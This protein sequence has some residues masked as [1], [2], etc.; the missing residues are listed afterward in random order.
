MSDAAW[1]RLAAPFGGDA[2][3]WVPVEVADAGDEVRV[4]ALLAAG[5]LRERFDRTVGIAGWGV[6]YTPLDAGAI[7]C[8]VTV[9]GVRKGAV[10]AAALA[11]GPVATAEVAFARAAELFGLRAPLPGGAAA[12]VPCDPE[13]LVPLH[14]PD[15]EGD[16]DV[17][18]PQA[19]AGDAFAGPGAGEGPSEPSSAGAER[20]PAAWGASAAV[21][22]A[23]VSAA[24]VAPAPAEK[25][26]GQQMI[27]RLVDRLK[28]EG[29][30]LAA[31]RLLVRYGGYGKD[32]DTARELYAQLRVLLRGEAAGH[33]AGGGPA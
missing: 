29:Q 28:D 5:A 8:H 25:P 21:A 24:P 14:L 19:G 18:A 33:P 9:A 20:G 17:G 27:D 1:S 4:V 15:V 13:T 26:T 16:V 3:A 6:A 12:W 30:G 7:A 23:S 32:P 10:A 22:P 11:G 2:I 31:A